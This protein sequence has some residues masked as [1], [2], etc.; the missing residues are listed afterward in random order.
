MIFMKSNKNVTRGTS[1]CKLIFFMET[2]KF[3]LVDRTITDTLSERFNCP[4]LLTASD[5][6]D[7]SVQDSTKRFVFDGFGPSFE[8]FDSLITTT[9]LPPIH[10]STLDAIL[11]EPLH[12]CEVL[13]I[14]GI[15]GTG[16]T[17]LC[18][19]IMRDAVHE[20]NCK[21]LFIDSDMN[22]SKNVLEMI[23]DSMEC[24]INSDIEIVRDPRVK[25]ENENGAI[26]IAACTDEDSAFDAIQEY[27]SHSTPDLVIIDSLFSLFQQVMGK[28]APGAP[29]LEEFALE[30]KSL[31]QRSG[32][33]VVVTNCL[34]AP[35][36]EPVTFLGPQYN[37]LWNSR[38][39]LSP[40]SQIVTSAKLVC[41]PRL[42]VQ[43][44]MFY[45]ETLK[46]C[47][48]QPIQTSE[49]NDGDDDDADANDV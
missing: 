29:Q 39:L 1:F 17:R 3:L 25:K 18:T 48:D 46:E 33:A 32:C 20:Q 28:D 31:A 26:T 45:L 38:I 22:L 7:A 2:P 42:P 27:F 43:E 30:L 8:T 6:L 16:K 13:S 41:S 12:R 24:N 9:D 15:G 36:G 10:L 47:S 11:G 49:A 44:K 34:K 5:L 19:K 14:E 21:V 37:Q 35:N 40:K 23:L 4:P